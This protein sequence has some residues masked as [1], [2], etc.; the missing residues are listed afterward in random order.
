MRFFDPPCGAMLA[1]VGGVKA[2]G[3]V[4]R[5]VLE[6]R[7]RVGFVVVMFVGC[8]TGGGRERT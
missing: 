1:V 5:V 2:S 3:W 6:R 4:G 8:E 7:A